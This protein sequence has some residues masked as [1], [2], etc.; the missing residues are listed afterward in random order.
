MKKLLLCVFLSVLSVGSY[1]NPECIVDDSVP[2]SVGPIT[3]AGKTYNIV[4]Y[5]LNRMGSTQT[6]DFVVFAKMKELINFE[7][8][9]PRVLSEGQICRISAQF[10]PMI[11]GRKDL[12]I[13]MRYVPMQHDDS[14]TL[15]RTLTVE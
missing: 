3:H 10:V 8:N 7:S 2:D 13:S 12:S 9:C 6:T 5:C 4:A 11:V 14:A 1:A 15:Q